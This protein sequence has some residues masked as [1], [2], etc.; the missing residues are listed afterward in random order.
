MEPTRKEELV[1][2]SIEYAIKLP[3]GE[4]LSTFPGRRP[5]N[6][7]IHSPNG[8]RRADT[9][10]EQP[11]VVWDE[12]Q[13]AANVADDLIRASKDLG[14]EDYAPVIV[15]RVVTVTRPPFAKSVF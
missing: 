1:T 8:L 5:S 4:L 15:E 6:E 13:H 2:S 9:W 11:V 12:L 3:N 7:N 14:V 10:E